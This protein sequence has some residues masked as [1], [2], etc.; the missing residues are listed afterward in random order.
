MWAAAL[1]R[2]LRAVGGPAT[3]ATIQLYG[4]VF[5]GKQKEAA[6]AFA[7][8]MRGG[9]VRA[10]VGKM[11]TKRDPQPLPGVFRLKHSRRVL[12]CG[13][14]GQTRTDDTLIFS[15]VLYHLSYLGSRIM[16]LTARRQCQGT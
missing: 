5:S 9:L 2:T 13:A 12:F 10:D 14:E 11:W 8:A 7:E 4:H 6:E 16:V 15:Q 3:V 1:L